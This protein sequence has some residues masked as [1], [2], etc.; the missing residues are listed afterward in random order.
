MFKRDPRLSPL[1]E[2]CGSGTYFGKIDVLFLIFQARQTRLKALS[3]GACNDEIS[4]LGFF[5][6]F[7]YGVM[8]MP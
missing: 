6:H 3:R 4:S 7:L 1:S 2:A 8:A 5:D